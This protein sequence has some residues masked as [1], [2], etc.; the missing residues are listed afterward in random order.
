MS[1]LEHLTQ[2]ERLLR[3]VADL[4]GGDPS[5][6]FASGM[7]ATSTILE[8]LDAGDHVIASDDFMVVH[9]D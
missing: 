2:L 7:A 3:I 4:E 6:A 8:L 5:F 1:I 9:T